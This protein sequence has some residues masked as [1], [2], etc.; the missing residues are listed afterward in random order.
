MNPNSLSGLI[1]VAVFAGVVLI[2]EF[3]HYIVSL[4]FKVEIEEFGIG[5]PPRAWKL[6]RNKGYFLLNN[7]RVEIPTNFDRSH[8]WFKVQDQECNIT[9]DKLDGRYILRT[10][11]YT[12]VEVKKPARVGKSAS[13]LDVDQSGKAV[14]PAAKSDEQITIK[15]QC[16]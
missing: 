10:I 3:G 4:L 7:E 12:Q 1:F 11:E 15:R 9:A 2:H 6:W 8:D 14:Q 13:H 16:Q 5:L